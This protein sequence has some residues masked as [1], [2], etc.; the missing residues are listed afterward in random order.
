MQH[1]F[2]LLFL[3]LMLSIKWQHHLYTLQDKTIELPQNFISWYVFKDMLFHQFF[4]FFKKMAVMGGTENFCYKWE[5]ARNGGR[6]DG[7]F[8][9]FLSFSKL[10][11]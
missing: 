4:R 3:K 1:H 6:G 5:K 8:L 7:K 9:K 2:S 10:R 11:K